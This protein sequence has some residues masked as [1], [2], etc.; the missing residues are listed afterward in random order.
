M[1][2]VAEDY[3]AGTHQSFL[4]TERAWYG[5]ALKTSINPHVTRF[6]PGLRRRDSQSQPVV[7]ERHGTGNKHS[8]D[9][10]RKRG[11]ASKR[12]ADDCQRRKLRQ[13]SHLEPSHIFGREYVEVLDGE[14]EQKET[15]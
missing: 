8:S 6:D 11:R 4:D 10:H 12:L 2:G 7:A 1:P 14:A 3:R 13:F 9:D 15:Y 5:E